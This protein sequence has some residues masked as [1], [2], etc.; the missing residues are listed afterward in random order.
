MQKTLFATA[1]LLLAF[2]LSGCIWPPVCGN[3]ICEIGESHDNCPIESGGDCPP[4]ELCGNGICNAAEGENN[5]NCP[6][7][8]PAIETH[9]ECQNQACTEVEGTGQDECA[10]DA[11]CQ[12]PQPCTE[13]NEG[14]KACIQDDAYICTYSKATGTLEFLWKKTMDCQQGCSDNYCIEENLYTCTGE[15]RDSVCY[16]KG[17]SPHAWPDNNYSDSDLYVSFE[18]QRSG[19]VVGDIITV[20]TTIQNKTDQQI[21]ANYFYSILEVGE[22]VSSDLLTDDSADK[23][24]PIPLNLQPHETRTF[25][26]TFRILHPVPKFLLSHLLQFG[27]RVPADH[28]EVDLAVSLT[29]IEP[30]EN[31]TIC[32][33]EKFPKQ[34]NYGGNYEYGTFKCCN[35]VFY[36]QFQCCADSDCV[37]AKC[38]DGK[39]LKAPALLK[40][41]AGNKKALVILFSRNEVDSNA[42]LVRNMQEMLVGVEEY[43]DAMAQRYLNESPDFINFDWEVYG[44]FNPA[45]LDLN[46]EYVTVA[47]VGGQRVAERAAEYCGLDFQSYE[48]VI[49]ISPDYSGYWCGGEGDCMAG[50]IYLS[51]KRPTTT[52][53]EL[54]HLFGC[55]DLYLGIGGNLQWRGELMSAGREDISSEDVPLSALPGLQ[56]CRGEMGWADLNDNGIIDVEE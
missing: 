25:T 28:K 45:M 10:S 40:K 56:V 31:Y 2:A 35:N 51:N 41:A 8:C 27:L 12:F 29:D 43:F 21:S 34:Y 20:D 52:A 39:C 38:V 46:E 49:V 37:D 23:S 33:A 9:F 44:K 26:S 6:E 54:A 15:V 48:E 11:N 22:K 5:T 55:N 18:Y 17:Y 19:F 16:N 24:D 14:E 50:T 47:Y 3:G 32:N 13:A 36:P 7:D 53:H 42:C 30:A 4:T 1:L